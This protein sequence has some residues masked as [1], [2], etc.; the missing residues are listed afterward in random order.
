MWIFKQSLNSSAEVAVKF[1]IS[2]P[3][4]STQKYEGVPQFYPV[5]IYLLLKRYATDDENAKLDSE[6]RVSDSVH[7][8]PLILHRSCGRERYSVAWCTRRKH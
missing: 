8:R 4:S 7:R 6:I 1:R 2:L 3:W 5:I